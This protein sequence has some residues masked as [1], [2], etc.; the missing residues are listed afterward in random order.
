[1]PEIKVSLK[2]KEGD[3]SIY[4]VEVR[5]GDSATKHE[6]EVQDSYAQKL[7]G[8][9]SSIEELVRDSFEFLLERE[10]K[11]SILSQFNLK[12]IEFYFPEF[13]SVISTEA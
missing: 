7:I 4:E 1:M 10:S 12:K 6:V 13:A 8:S 11:E 2:S 3:R 9:R 5:E